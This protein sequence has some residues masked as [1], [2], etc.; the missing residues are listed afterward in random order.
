MPRRQSRITCIQDLKNNN[1]CGP[2][3]IRIPDAKHLPQ[4]KKRF[5]SISHFRYNEGVT[6]YRERND[7]RF[8]TGDDSV[9]RVAW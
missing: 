7:G 1:N 9:Y 6:S 8:A 5:V 4:Q 3:Y 2:R